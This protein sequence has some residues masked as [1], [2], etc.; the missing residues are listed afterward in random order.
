MM[1]NDIQHEL[2]SHLGVNE[3]LLWVGEPKQGVIF[4]TSDIFVIPFSIFW[5]GFALFWEFTV[6]YYGIP[7]F[8]IFGLFFV[9]MG[10]YF[11]IGRFIYD[12]KNRK[13][14]IYGI[15][16]SRVLIRSGIFKKEVK[17]LNIKVLPHITFRENKNGS[18]TV[19][20]GYDDFRSRFGN[21]TIFN[22]RNF[23][24]SF[25]CI[26]N[27]KKVYDIL[28]SIQTETK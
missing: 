13:N 23:P 9:V 15:T 20:F 22:T 5:F 26:P 17:S 10:L 11:I 4:R 19:L 2:K 24:P 14:T 8:A 16:E 3:H 12:A 25:E 1:H 7:V 21:R 27:V 18:G 6:I 28:V